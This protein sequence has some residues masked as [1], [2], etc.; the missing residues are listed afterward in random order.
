[1]RLA[2]KLWFKGLLAAFISGV[3][4]S[5]LSALGISGAQAV[6]VNITQLT[7]KQ[8]GM[9]TLMGGLVG[10]ALYWKQSPV[11]PDTTGNTERFTKPESLRDPDKP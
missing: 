4:T 8:L 3:S 9:T 2:T 1:M 11:P 6:G 7:P 10:V 5:F